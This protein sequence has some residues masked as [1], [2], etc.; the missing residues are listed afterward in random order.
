MRKG[1]GTWLFFDTYHKLRRTYPKLRRTYPKLWRQLPIGAQKLR[2]GADKFRVGAHKF[3]VVYFIF[4]IFLNKYVKF[5][6]TLTSKSDKTNC[7][8]I[9]TAMPFDYYLHV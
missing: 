3:R 7:I 5:L 9:T 2:V 8:L 6:L 4:E 1:I